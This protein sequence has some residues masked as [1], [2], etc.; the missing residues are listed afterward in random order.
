M[1]LRALLCLLPLCGAAVGCDDDA[2]AA[3]DAA[4]STDARLDGSVTDEGVAGDAG[5]TPDAAVP[6][7]PEQYILEGD[8]LVPESGDFDPETRDFYVSSLVHGT[9]T[10]VRPDGTSVVF[11][12]PMEAGMG[13]LGVRIDVARRLWTCAVRLDDLAGFVWVYDLTTGARAFSVDLSTVAPEASCNDIAFDLQGYAYVTDR[14]HPNVYRVDP[15]TQTAELFV[16]DPS[17]TGSIG[18]NGIALTEDARALIVSVLLPAALY[19]I[20]LGAEHTVA[21]VALSGDA[22][23]G[24]MGITGADGIRMAHGELLVAMMDTLARVVPDDATWATATV[25]TEGIPGGTSAVVLAEGDVYTIQSDVVNQVLGRP[26]TLPF[27]ITRVG[28]AEAPR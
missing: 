25:H 19:R 17:L 13:T 24:A 10:R 7:L 5:E 18:M 23:R 21:P 26:L 12:E 20:D 1:R 2:G 9:L 11:A 22:F 14:E 6:A 3:A 15:A 16:T 27:T 4:R 28:T 8:D